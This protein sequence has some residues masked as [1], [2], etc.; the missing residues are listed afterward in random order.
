[1]YYRSMKKTK[2]L[3][4]VS[5][6]LEKSQMQQLDIRAQKNDRTRSYILRDVIDKVLST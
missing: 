6:C 3:I 5:V 4:T 1:M 2:E